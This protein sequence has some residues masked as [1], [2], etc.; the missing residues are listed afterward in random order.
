[1]RHQPRSRL[2][3]LDFEQVNVGS[4]SRKLQNLVEA[5]VQPRGLDIVEDQGH[6]KNLPKS[7]LAEAGMR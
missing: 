6:A 1:M 7:D 5:L 3:P 4:D 2:E